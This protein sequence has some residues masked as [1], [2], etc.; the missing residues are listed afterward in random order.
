MTKTKTNIVSSISKKTGSS[1][2]DIEKIITE[3]VR[4]LRT[5]AKSNKTTVVPGFGYVILR[6]RKAPYG[7]VKHMEIPSAASWYISDDDELYPPPTENFQ[8]IVCQYWGE[9][10]LN[11]INELQSGRKSNEVIERF[12]K[13]SGMPKKLLAEEVFE[14]SPKTLANYCK[15]GKS[16][17]IRLNE[18]V[19]KL[20]KLYEK[21]I[22]LFGTS[23]R[24]NTWLKAK[25]YGLGNIKP[26][27]II[28][29]ITGIELVYEELIR[30]EFGAT[31]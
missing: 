23:K 1:E 17:P 26:I 28:N 24:F 30:I 27:S 12:L 7:S 20:E 15:P 5:A 16:L 11:I 9:T 10:R 29:S 2:S 22:E 19:L 25:S 13:I 8:D 4:T 21:G 31:A 18:Q 14:I 3:F 6:D